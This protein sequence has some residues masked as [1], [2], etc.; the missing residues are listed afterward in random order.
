MIRID[1]PPQAAPEVWA[2]FKLIEQVYRQA[3]ADARRGN[4]EAAY[5]LD[6]TLP[7][8]RQ[9]AQPTRRSGWRKG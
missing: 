7:D 8:W 5:F 4:A 2:M 9:S 1:R 3:I 6:C